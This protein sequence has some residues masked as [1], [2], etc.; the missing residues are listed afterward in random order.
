MCRNQFRRANGRNSQKLWSQLTITPENVLTI[1]P[2]LRY[3][4]KYDQIVMQFRFE[5]T[6]N[7]FNHHAT[8]ILN[9]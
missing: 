6:T 3:F 9:R 5:F 1:E 2:Y 8:T 4:I 7:F